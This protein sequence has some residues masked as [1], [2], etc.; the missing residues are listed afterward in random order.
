MTVNNLEKRNIHLSNDHLLCYDKV[1]LTTH[2]LIHCPY[3]KEVCTSMINEFRQ[4]WVVPENLKVLLMGWKIGAPS[5][6]GK[7]LWILV[8]AAIWH[9]ILDVK[10]AWV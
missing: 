5:E 10:D 8:P 1:E 6:R 7:Q 2:L 9:G 3:T 4:A